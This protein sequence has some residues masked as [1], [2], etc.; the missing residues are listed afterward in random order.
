MERTVENMLHVMNENTSFRLESSD[1][2][3]H[4][5]KPFGSTKRYQSLG[6]SGRW[7]GTLRMYHKVG[8]AY[9]ENEQ[10]FEGGS[11]LDVVNQA[12]DFYLQV[13]GLE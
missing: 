3:V 9:F 6:K 5:L 2:T 4:T 13:V 8:N 11:P 7:Y 1:V 12:Y 10:T